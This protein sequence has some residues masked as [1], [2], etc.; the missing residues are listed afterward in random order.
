MVPILT[1]L[2]GGFS[3]LYNIT[4]SSAA[5]LSKPVIGAWNYLKEKAER[6]DLTEQRQMQTWQRQ[7]WSTKLRDLAWL[8]LRGAGAAQRLH[9]ANRYALYADGAPPWMIRRIHRYPV[10]SQVWYPK[11]RLYPRRRRYGG[12]ART[13]PTIAWGRTRRT[14]SALFRRRRRRRQYSM[15]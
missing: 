14:R 3:N 6:D 11:R 2:D 12:R 5:I 7:P 4:R 10:R 8:G 15:W 13:I 1:G 9:R